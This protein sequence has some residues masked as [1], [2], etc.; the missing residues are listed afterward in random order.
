MADLLHF[1]DFAEGQ[2]YDLGT[3]RLDSEEIVAFARE[4]DPQPQHLDPEAAKRSILGGHAASGWQLCALAMRMIVDGLLHRA[5]SQGSPG[6][7]EVQWRRPVL[8]GDTLR[9]T[10]KVLNVR[11]S[12]KPDRG[13]VT[14]RFEMS[15]NDQMVMMFESAIIL[16]RAS[17]GSA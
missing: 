11:P 17:A 1:E 6:V 3:H 9:L 14:F 10:G 4:F 13:F 16:G 2:V 8:A 5:A 12:S 15:R 7:E